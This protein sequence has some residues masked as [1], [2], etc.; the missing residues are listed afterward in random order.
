MRSTATQIKGSC[1]S[2]VKL[3]EY[4]KITT[5]LAIMTLIDHQ[6]YQVSMIEL[7]EALILTSSHSIYRKNNPN[8]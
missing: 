2:K 6:E 4:S 8:R 3:N 1:R 7:T 5:T